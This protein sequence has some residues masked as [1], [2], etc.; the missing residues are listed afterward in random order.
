[1]NT[2]APLEESELREK[3]QTLDGSDCLILSSWL[4]KHPDTTIVIKDKK[5]SFNSGK[6]Y[7]RF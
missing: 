3:F 5:K 6:N 1:M 7:Q 2:A 4:E